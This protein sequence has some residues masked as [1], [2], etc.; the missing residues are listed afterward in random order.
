MGSYGGALCAAASAACVGK[1]SE[2]DGREEGMVQGVRAARRW[3]VVLLALWWCVCMLAA[4]YGANAAARRIRMNAVERTCLERT[5]RVARD[6]EAY[7]RASG[8]ESWA[9]FREARQ[10]RG[11]ALSFTAS[12]ELAYAFLTDPQGV[13][14][15]H[16]DVSQ[17]GAR[18]E[19]HGANEKR[20][21]NAPVVTR[22]MVSVGGAVKE[23]LDVGVP[24]RM[25]GGG[26]GVL[27][28]G[29]EVSAALTG[30]AG[31]LEAALRAITMPVVGLLGIGMLA[32]AWAGSG[33]VVRALERETEAFR[34]SVERE[35]EVIGAGI[36]HEV[37]NALNGIHMNAQMVQEVC[38]TL[39]EGVRERVMKYTGRILH[40]AGQTGRML[41]EFL[42]YAKP[43]AYAPAATNVVA[44]LE[45]V[46]Q[47]FEHECRRRGIR[48]K[49]ETEAVLS[50]V[51][52][53]EQLLRHG[54][55]NMMWNA[56]Q[57]IEQNGEVILR[58]KK[59]GGDVTLAVSDT[60]GGVAREIEG[61]IFEVFFSSKPGGA[62]LGLSIVQRVARAHGGR[63]ELENRPGQGCTFTLRF[64]Y[65]Q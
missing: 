34:R 42:S 59:E 35:V 60:G 11:T 7:L 37:K 44:L 55:T 39:P 6:V 64:P 47:F 57:A 45:D 4:Y 14:I 38:G 12:R 13:I 28:A 58:G 5:L 21:T 49:C 16:S 1:M 50:S 40:E 43:A 36:V 10:Q 31:D 3:S 65:R 52:A 48:V 46:A 27:R 2:R 20:G 61:M 62:G 24:V 8:C 22:M 53:D 32:I 19:S 33:A 23:I 18:V 26:Q 29:F 56:I 51:R 17:E 9:A 25:E 30:V 54:L 41:N 63:V 15:I